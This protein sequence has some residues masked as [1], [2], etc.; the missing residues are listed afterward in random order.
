MRHLAARISRGRLAFRRN[1][2]H[3]ALWRAT[4]APPP[5]VWLGTP[6]APR[7]D[8]LPAIRVAARFSCPGGSAAAELAPAS[9]F[10][11]RWA[12]ATRDARRCEQCGPWPVL[13]RSD[14]VAP[15]RGA[16]VA[17]LLARHAGDWSLVFNVL[18]AALFRGTAARTARQILYR[19]GLSP[20]E[21]LDCLT[22]DVLSHQPSPCLGSLH[23]LVRER[24]G[25][26][27]A[28]APHFS[29]HVWDMASLTPYEGG[30]ANIADGGYIAPAI[31][32]DVVVAADGGAAGGA[33]IGGRAGIL[34]ASRLVEQTPGARSALTASFAA[35]SARW[36]ALEG[37][38]PGWAEYAAVC[39]R[40]MQTILST[41]AE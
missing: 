34:Y 4:A 6:G 31:G 9:L 25:A 12:L 2:A 32:V 36:L 20:G 17:L 22:C 41:P 19:S 15:F 24:C 18:R 16:A 29:R 38:A 28:S 39:I 13:P 5:K 7:V 33:A 14:A 23:W 30:A 35:D 3:E 8:A 27:S 11:Y 1:T 26:G 37:D 40:R 21:I 10:A